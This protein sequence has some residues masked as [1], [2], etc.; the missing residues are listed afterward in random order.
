M[1]WSTVEIGVI[2]LLADAPKVECCKFLRN[3]NQYIQKE[4]CR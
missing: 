2:P 4:G 3:S 1:K